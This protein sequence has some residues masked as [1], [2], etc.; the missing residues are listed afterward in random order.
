[1]YNGNYRGNV[2]IEDWVIQS[3]LTCNTLAEQRTII[4][5]GRVIKD[6][7]KEQLRLTLGDNGS[8]NLRTGL[9]RPPLVSGFQQTLFGVDVSHTIGL[10]WTEKSS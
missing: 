6:F 2:N 7:Q 9:Q 5:G 8:P 3:E 4:S 10:D 1:M